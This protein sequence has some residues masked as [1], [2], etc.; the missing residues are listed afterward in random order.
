MNKKEVKRCPKCRSILGTFIETGNDHGERIRETRYYCERCG[1]FGERD[2]KKIQSEKLKDKI[3]KEMIGLGVP[4]DKA[5][6]K[7]RQ[8]ADEARSG[9]LGEWS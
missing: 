2:L 6:D 9:K 4:D 3:V 1:T 8:I 7:A 5:A